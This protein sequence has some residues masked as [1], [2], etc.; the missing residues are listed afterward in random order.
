MLRWIPRTSGQRR[1]AV[2]AVVAAMWTASACTTPKK[3][4]RWKGPDGSAEELAA[5]RAE[6][7]KRAFEAADV[8][9]DRIGSNMMINEFLKCMKEKGWE[10]EERDDDDDDDDDDD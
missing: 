5:A 9:Y 8:P 10:L 4:L 7:E 1:L 2:L 3:D 6:C